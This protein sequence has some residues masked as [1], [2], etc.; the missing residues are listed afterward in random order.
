MIYVKNTPNNTGVAI[1]GDFMF[2]YFRQLSQN[3]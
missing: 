3:A 1:Y 2:G